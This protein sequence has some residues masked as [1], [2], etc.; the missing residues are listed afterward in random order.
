MPPT[1]ENL[2]IV[3]DEVRALLDGDPNI[4]P[5]LRALIKLM[6]GFIQAL[7]AQKGLNSRNSSKPPAADP[8]RK[9]KHA[10]T[11]WTKTR[12]AARPHRFHP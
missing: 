11:F 8:I 12:W 6:L 10:P 9:K 2:D 3:S 1:R 4:S 7:S 5:A